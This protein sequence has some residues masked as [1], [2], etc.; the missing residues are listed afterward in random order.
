MNFE[1]I[2]KDIKKLYC[3]L[4]AIEKKIFTATSVTYLQLKKLLDSS[5]L[6]PNSKY[7]ITDFQTLH[8]IPNTTEKNDTNKVIP[9]ENLLLTA[10]SNNTFEPIVTSLQYPDDIIYYDIT[11]NMSKTYD[12]IDLPTDHK[13]WIWKR[14]AGNITAH[15]DFVCVHRTWHAD[16]SP[17][18]LHPSDT[19]VP[20]LSNTSITAGTHS[21][22]ESA[23]TVTTNGN[24]TDTFPYYDKARPIDIINSR[25]K[26][27]FGRLKDNVVLFSFSHPNTGDEVASC[28][29]LGGN[30]KN[31]RVHGGFS[32]F[33]E[34][35][36]E[37]IYHYP[38]SRYASMPNW[39]SPYI[40]IRG[41][42][43]I[44]A[45][46]S[47]GYVLS[48]K[49]HSC[50]EYVGNMTFLMSNQA[51]YNFDRTLCFLEIYQN[52]SHLYFSQEGTLNFSE[53]IVENTHCLNIKGRDIKRNNLY[54]NYLSNTGNKAV[55]ESADVLDSIN[56]KFVREYAL[57][58][59][60][61]LDM[62]NFDKFCYASVI[63]MLDGS[64]INTVNRATTEKGY[65]PSRDL[66]IKSIGSTTINLGTG[67]IKGSGSIAL[68]AG[69][70]VTL[71]EIEYGTYV[72]IYS[73]V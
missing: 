51:G 66:T 6:V 2:L 53:G 60:G 12:D 52:S 13:G 43:G 10:T 58:T 4:T 67:N 49:L 31:I 27:E 29:K 14:T 16:W 37:D 69:N 64:V 30:L 18:T 63:E 50:T 73:D 21:T 24:Y 5:S 54:L 47:G 61:V 15:H 41:T 57:V 32:I 23:I 33:E 42:G 7:L 39:W 46:I 62:T 48:I 68:L 56:Y 1:K 45:I 20:M 9:V 59:T 34:A 19:D 38:S 3:K 8:I 36:V 28:F 44:K 65:N 40:D 22:N 71:K 17:F 35:D 26:G 55:I 70:V 25:H 72:V 11:G